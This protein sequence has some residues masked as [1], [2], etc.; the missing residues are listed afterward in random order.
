MIYVQIILG[1]RTLMSNRGCYTVLSPLRTCGSHK[2]S[3]STIVSEP[4]QYCHP[5]T[6]L[7]LSSVECRHVST[8]T[9]TPSTICITQ[10]SQILLLQYPQY[11]VTTRP[12]TLYHKVPRLSTITP[13]PSNITTLVVVAINP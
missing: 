11:P 4:Y 2:S 3:S 13:A 6:A 9:S 5:I 12:G 7:A 1:R 10:P 8:T